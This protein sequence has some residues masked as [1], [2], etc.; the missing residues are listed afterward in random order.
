MSKEIY[1]IRHGR[2]EFNRLGIWQGSGVDSSLD[3]VGKEQAE[4]FFSTYRDVEFDL[5][6]HSTLKRSK[7][8]VSPFIEMGRETHETALINEISW[9]DF[10]GKVH[11]DESL[12][13]Y[14]KVVEEW[15]SGQ[16]ESAL[17]GGESARALEL[18]LSNFVEELKE[19]SQSKIL[20]CSHGRAIRGLLC[21]MKNEPMSA[22][23]NYQ[24][25]NT[26]LFKANFYNGK[27]DFQTYNNIDH[28]EY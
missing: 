23:E 21:V 27:F 8:T 14:K 17:P 20:I 19:L 1:L 12:R 5:V 16:Y 2:T 7:E 4:R 11:T 18:R 28:L 15:G 13:N 26:G 25:A 9:G 24:H 10:E 6:I 3:S 22:M